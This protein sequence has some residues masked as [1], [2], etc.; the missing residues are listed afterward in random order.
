MSDDLYRSYLDAIDRL[1]TAVG[2]APD[3]R[4]AAEAAT[5]ARLE[6]VERRRSAETEQLT[7]RLGRA[8]S[9]YRRVAA[10]LDEPDLANLGLH[11]PASL[12]PAP[13]A[14]G[15]VEDAEYEQERAVVALVGAVNNHRVRRAAEA[16]AAREA[17]EAL[18]ARRAALEAARNQPPPRRFDPRMVA[19][20][21][22][23]VLLLL[24]VIVVIVM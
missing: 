21:G 18:A 23:L 7:E 13:D 20:A 22:V 2:A 17:A 9:A 12:T 4:A 11:L 10:V 19:V 6:S 15:S 5:R 14:R 1:S 8:K 24:I 16:E 3:A